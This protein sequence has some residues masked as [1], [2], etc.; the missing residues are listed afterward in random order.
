MIEKLIVIL[1]TH[2]GYKIVTDVG[3]SMFSGWGE[4]RKIIVHDDIKT[5]E[6]E[7]D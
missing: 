5:I 1:I 4:L 2:K 6:L 3:S 7:F